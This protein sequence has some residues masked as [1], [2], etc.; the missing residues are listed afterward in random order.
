VRVSRLGARPL[1][2]VELLAAVLLLPLLQG[3]L[4]RRGAVVSV[5]ISVDGRRFPIGIRTVPDVH[6][7]NEVLAARVYD[8]GPLRS[9]QVIV[10]A[11][12]NIGAAPMFFK[13]R[14]PHARI[15]AIEPD[16]RAFAQLEANAGHL[17]GGF[18]PP[19]AH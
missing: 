2:R 8:V 17:P 11:G 5:R 3:A 19:L 12:A 15:L 6:V 7:L 4:L 18:P 9:A 1:D 14:R 16:P 10:D 13:A